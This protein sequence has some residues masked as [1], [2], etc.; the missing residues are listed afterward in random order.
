MGFK[1]GQI[2]QKVCFIPSFLCWVPS[3]SS[4]PSPEPAAFASYPSKSTFCTL[5]PPLLV[6][7]H[8]SVCAPNLPSR[9]D[10]GHKLGTCQV[11]DPANMK[12]TLGCQVPEE[13]FEKLCFAGSSYGQLICGC[14]RNC[15]IM[16][17]FTGAKV[18]SPQ[19]PFTDNTY[20]YSGMLSAPLASPNS[21]LL[22]CTVSK[23]DALVEVKKLEN[24]SLFIGSDVRSS[25][26]SCAS[27][28]RW[29][30][31]SNCLYYGYYDPPLVL[32]GIGDDADAVCDPD[33]GPDDLVFKSLVFKRNWNTRLQPFWLYPSMLYR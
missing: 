31:R 8:I 1:G 16:D 20:F 13:T 25:T 15:L 14:G 26:F 22:V 9:S 30:G 29:S 24:Y 17:V 2:S 21:H 27:L 11:L 33:Y 32:H 7:P 12:S 5:L 19:L 28:G 10:D 6:Q 3:L 23:Q 18:L 4:L